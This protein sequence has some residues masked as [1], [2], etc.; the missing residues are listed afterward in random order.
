MKTLASFA[1]G[2]YVLDRAMDNP[3][4]GSQFH[5]NRN[6]VFPV[7]MRV[8]VKDSMLIR[9]IYPFGGEVPFDDGQVAA[10]LP[11][12]SPAEPQIGQF[13]DANEMQE[14]LARLV[15]TGVLTVAQVKDAWMDTR[16]V[17]SRITVRETQEEQ[18]IETLI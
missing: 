6:P 16:F 12:L 4:S 9:R 15:S 14:V 7:G 17:M 13:V 11:C 3:S 1:P 5:P 8:H 18:W 2:F 10:L